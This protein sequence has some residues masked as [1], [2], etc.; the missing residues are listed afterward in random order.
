MS[1]RRAI[2]APFCQRGV[3]RMNESGFIVVLS[4]EREWFSAD[5][6]KRLV[7][8]GAGEGL[9]ER[10]NGELRAT[11][12]PVAVDLPEGFEPDEDVLRARSTFERML[13]RIVDRGIEKRTA[14][15]EINQLQA[16]LAVSIEAAAA[17][18]ARQNG[19]DA[20]DIAGRA[21]REL[22]DAR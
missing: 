13:D 11:F 2:A 20:T 15:A 7:D 8:I 10:E 19:I 17:L 16:D 1:L 4:L 18:Y 5:Q 14:V 21:R 22:R 6:A 9:L 12:D 3:E